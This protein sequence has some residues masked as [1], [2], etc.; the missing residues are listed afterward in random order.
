MVWFWDA[1]APD[2]EDRK[3]TTASPLSATTEQLEGLPPALI[4]TDEND[5]LR[6]EG[7][8]Y[9][10]KLIQAGVDVRRFVLVLVLVLERGYSYRLALQLCGS[11]LSELHPR[12]A[13]GEGVDRV[14][15]LW[16]PTTA[17]DI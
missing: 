10:R 9:A 13:H 15:R 3:K 16:S 6:D 5:V 1:Y 2:K 7:E 8:A 12:S 11:A 17:S 4:I 14:D